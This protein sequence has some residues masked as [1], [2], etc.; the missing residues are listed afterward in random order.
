[1]I[2]VA[3]VGVFTGVKSLALDVESDAF[4]VLDYLNRISLQAGA[5]VTELKVRQ[6]KS[7]KDKLYYEMMDIQ[8]LKMQFGG[9]VSIIRDNINKYALLLDRYK[10][11]ADLKSRIQNLASLLK[12][13]DETFD[14]TY[15][16][17]D[18]LMASSR[19][20]RAN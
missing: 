17:S 3:A 4:K 20:Y 1:M 19:M 5:Y 12:Q 18:Y 2:P 10:T 15:P 14:K 6:P 16:V 13:V 9:K 11:D 8:A 7:W